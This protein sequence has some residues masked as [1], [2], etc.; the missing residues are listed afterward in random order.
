MKVAVIG[1]GPSYT[2]YDGWGD[3]IVGCKIGA[4][5][6][7]HYNF[8]VNA[9]SSMFD[10]VLDDSWNINFPNRMI[11]PIHMHYILQ[12]WYSADQQAKIKSKLSIPYDTELYNSLPKP[13]QPN[14]ARLV[15][16]DLKGFDYNSQHKISTGHWAI[17]FAIA[18]YEVD[19][20]RCYGFDAHFDPTLKIQSISHKVTASPEE[21]KRRKNRG[22]H[23]NRGAV[24]WNDTVDFL[25]ELYCIPIQLVPP[26]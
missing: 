18:L 21:L 22:W 5:L 11:Y 26:K 1:N 3:V 10:K 9:H 6:G 24:L 20:V 2:Q 7:V 13:F 8:C 19:E 15:K 25:R 23:Y 17:I 16:R 12:N 14:L 4:P